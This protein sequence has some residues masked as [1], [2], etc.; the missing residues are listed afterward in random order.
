MN[1]I[2]T[3]VVFITVYLHNVHVRD[4]VLQTAMTAYICELSLRLKYPAGPHVFTA[5]HLLQV[6]VL[7]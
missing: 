5:I 3:K 6:Q 2:R 1:Q 4:I 7:K